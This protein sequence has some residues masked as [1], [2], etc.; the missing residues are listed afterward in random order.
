MV[1]STPENDPMGDVSHGRT[2]TAPHTLD[3]FTI[4]ECIPIGEAARIAGRTERTIRN[5]CIEHGIGRRIGGRWAIS[6]VAL[7]MWLDGKHDA[8]VAYRDRGVR[9][10]WEPVASGRRPTRSFR[11]NSI[12]RFDPRAFQFKYIPKAERQA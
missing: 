7:M 9:A 12:S 8:L 10:S 4:E 1:R 6:K 3:P 5:W 2:A 11:R